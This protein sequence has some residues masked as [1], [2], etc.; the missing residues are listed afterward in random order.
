[1]N[2]TIVKEILSYWDIILGIAAII[3]GV[4]KWYKLTIEIKNRSAYLT[5]EER[6]RFRNHDNFDYKIYGLLI[7]F[8]VL[9]IYNRLKGNMPNIIQIFT[10]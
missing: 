8:G 5:K 3:I 9:F 6:W 1:M 4:Y 7:I 10:P 2:C